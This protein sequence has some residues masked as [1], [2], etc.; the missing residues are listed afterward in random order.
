MHDSDASQSGGS[1]PKEGLVPSVPPCKWLTERVGYSG[2][3]I[4]FIGANPPGLHSQRDAITVK[5]QQQR[6]CQTSKTADDHNAIVW[7]LSPSNAARMTTS[8]LFDNGS[9]KVEV[10]EF[11]IQDPLP[12][13]QLQTSSTVQLRLIEIV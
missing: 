8:H 6:N 11:Q 5:S 4:F 7:E 1:L 12:E 10:F 9:C 3:R 2:V 13:R